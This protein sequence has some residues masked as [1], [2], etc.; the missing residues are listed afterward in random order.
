MHASVKNV[1]LVTI[2]SL[3]YD[4]V[5][6]YGEVANTTPTIDTLAEDGIKFG[7]AIATASHTKDSFPGILTSS[8]PS[9]QGC[10]HISEDKTSIAE[11]FRNEG[12]TTA[13]FHSTPMMNASNNYDSGF[14]TL[15]D[16]AEHE[17]AEGKFNSFLQFIPSSLLGLGHQLVERYNLVD[18]A[19]GTESTV[20][21]NELT[22]N[23][24][25]YLAEN[26]EPRFLF[27]HYMD[28]HTPYKPPEKY[29]QEFVGEQLSDERIG[30]V[31]DAL[32]SNKN[33][34]RGN[35]GNVQKGDLELA[36]ELYKG[37]I[38]FVDEEIKRIVNTLKQQ[39]EWEDTLLIV[40]A[41]H[42]EEFGEHGGFFHGQKL[43]EEVIRVPL[44]IAG[45]QAVNHHVESQ[46]SLLDLAPTI[47]D[48]S[49]IPIAESMLGETLAS[50]VQYGQPTTEYALAESTVKQLG[51]D[52]GRTIAC[53]AADGRKLIWNE[54]EVE[55][56]DSEF[57]FYDL[58][59]DPDESKHTID[60]IS[61]SS[62][63][64]LKESIELL[65]QGE[66]VQDEIDHAAEDRL[67]SLG[68][69]E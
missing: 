34:S 53:R 66:I 62:L 27:V 14:N 32:L 28:A 13:G 52:V 59:E 44:I 18:R 50:A 39:D 11:V 3:R 5:S 38:R 26:R 42:G 21:A 24:I 19:A 36:K 63:E 8:L 4:Y 12:Y 29:Q 58:V 51:Q 22:D 33:L 40:T 56:C 9:E 69:L 60:G 16:L 67:K 57:E 1:L 61:Q 49:G 68:Y 2:D 23:V 17:S 48:L 45:G 47:L 65:K 15:V 55:W 20:D 64:D 25:G 6:C 54:S 10:H 31:N 30:E 43:Y 7:E 46:V 41:D 37:T 35:P